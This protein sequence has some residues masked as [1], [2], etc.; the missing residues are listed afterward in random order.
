MNFITKTKTHFPGKRP[1]SGRILYLFL[2]FSSLAIPAGAQ[3][4]AILT[5]DG[6][7]TSARFAGALSRQLE[8]K[9]VVLDDSLSRAAYLATAPTTPFNMTTGEAKVV[10]SAIGCDVFIM[11]RAATQRRSAFQRPEYYESYAAIYVVS[12][13]TGRLVFWRLA[14]FEETKPDKAEKRLADSIA[15]LAAMI[16]DSMRSA[17]KSEM[18]ETDP[19]AIEEVPDEGSAAARNLRPPIPYRRIKPEY[20]VDAAMYDVAATVD[21]LVDLGADGSILRT[22]HVRWAGFGLD[23]SVEKTIRTMN[24]RPATRGDKP[25]PMRFLL[26][27][28]FRKIEKEQVR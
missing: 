14:R 17:L 8:E 11:V 18:A 2:I 13:R 16:A 22:E 19:A 26:R 15:G 12:T 5:P 9:V 1:G 21:I 27:Y 3:K 10:G 7:E 4:I 23:E 24:W 28:N 25:L 20:T 6:A